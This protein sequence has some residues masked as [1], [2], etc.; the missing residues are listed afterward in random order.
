MP[1]E[2]NQA[3]PNALGF[4]IGTSAPTMKYLALSAFMIGI[5]GSFALASS[6]VLDCLTE[7]MNEF[8]SGTMYLSI[9]S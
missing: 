9:K 5:S 2:T 1:E 3:L 7:D 6:I 4:R 8:I